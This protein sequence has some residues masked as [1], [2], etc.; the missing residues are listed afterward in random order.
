MSHFVD[1]SACAV[2]KNCP[3]PLLLWK[4]GD[5]SA[6][7][8]ID[9]LNRYICEDCRTL[10]CCSY[11]KKFGGYSQY[12]DEAVY[13]LCEATHELEDD[14]RDWDH[15]TECDALICESCGG[16]DPDELRCGK[17][18]WDE[19]Q[20]VWSHDGL[21]SLNED[22]AKWHRFPV[23]LNP[24]YIFRA[25]EDTDDDIERQVDDYIERQELFASAR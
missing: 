14:M 8:L 20:E 7:D 5:A 10:L 9:Q 15:C 13:A 22:I 18:L 21:E 3:G 24:R 17:C 19:V 2:C 1:V 16:D 12:C 11:C 25:D 23:T 4:A 6:P